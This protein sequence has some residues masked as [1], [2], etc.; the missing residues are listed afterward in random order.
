MIS[1][2]DIRSYHCPRWQE[3]PD[4]ELYMDQV[5]SVLDKNLAIFIDR[6]PSKAITS[7]MINNYVKQKLVRPPVNK[8]YDRGHIAHFFIISLLKQIM[9]LGQIRDTIRC[10][11]SLCSPEEA[12]DR[13]CEIFEQSLK[14]VFFEEKS[15]NKRSAGNE[16][17]VI[18]SVCLAFANM[19]YAQYLVDSLLPEK[20][21]PVQ[22]EK[23]KKDKEKTTA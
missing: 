7:T 1:L 20:E 17:A 22:K 21:A 19:L 18:R 12:Y 8:R 6:D 16:D 5:K 14:S 13:F 11:T 4:L 15:G 2:N 23:K 9:S 3:L 10:V